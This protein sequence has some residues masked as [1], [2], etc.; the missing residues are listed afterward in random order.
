MQNHFESL[1]GNDRLKIGE[2]VSLIY[3]K[4][5]NEVD[6]VSQMNDILQSGISFSGV[7]VLGNVYVAT[8]YRLDADYL[9]VVY[10]KQWDTCSPIE[11]KIV[12]SI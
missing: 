8:W 2:N 1:N 3:D 7:H 11:F 4:E 12:S 6:N 5:E 9:M 10:K